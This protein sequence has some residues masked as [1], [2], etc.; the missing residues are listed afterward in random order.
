MKD[1]L[2]ILAHA[3]IVRRYCESRGFCHECI[4][5]RIDQNGACVLSFDEIPEEWKT[6]E[7]F[8]HLMQKETERS[9]EK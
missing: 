1:D 6:R 8:K 7:L 2:K 5:Y 4:F 9:E 3:D